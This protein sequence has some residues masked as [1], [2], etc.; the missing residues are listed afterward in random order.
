MNFR[1]RPFDNDNDNSY[2]N[3]NNSILSI[4]DISLLINYSI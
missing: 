2:P 3:N 1:R 4:I